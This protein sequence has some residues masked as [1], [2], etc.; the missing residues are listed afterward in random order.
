M[1]TWQIIVIICCCSIV[2]IVVIVAI[3]SCYC[4]SKMRLN[5]NEAAEEEANFYHINYELPCRMPTVPTKSSL[6][7]MYAINE[8]QGSYSGST[9][10]MAISGH[11]LSRRESTDSPSFH[12]DDKTALD[13]RDLSKNS[14]SSA[15]RY[16][17]RTLNETHLTSR[18]SNG[19]RAPVKKE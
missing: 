3:L 17:L 10:S 6:F 1:A 4:R 8:H 5:D 16:D 9:S 2:F 14:V 7:N 19:V 13:I 18:Y 15:L 11:Q 12:S